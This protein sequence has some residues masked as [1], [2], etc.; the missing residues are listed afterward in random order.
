MSRLL[1]ARS[2][3]RNKMKGNGACWQA[4]WENST[5]DENPGGQRNILQG[6][7]SLSRIPQTP[8]ECLRRPFLGN[9]EK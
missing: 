1:Q 8:R 9:V 4:G 5:K 6:L 2:Y 3:A 7:S